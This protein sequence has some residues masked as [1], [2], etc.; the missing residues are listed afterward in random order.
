MRRELRQRGVARDAECS[1]LS[2]GERR[3]HDYANPAAQR[4]RHERGPLLRRIAARG[5]A[6]VRR[7]VLR[8]RRIPSGGAQPRPRS[9]VRLRHRRGGAPRLLRQLRNRARRRHRRR[10]ARGCSRPRPA[11]RGLPLSALLDHRPAAR[12][13]RPAR[14]ALLRGAAPHPR[15]AAPRRRLGERQ[16]TRDGAGRQSPRCDPRRASRSGLRGGASRA[17]RAGLRPSPEARAHHHRRLP[18]SVRALP[19]A[20]RKSADDAARRPPREA[21]RPEALRL[22]LHTPLQKSPADAAVPQRYGT[23]TKAATYPVIP[24]R[25]RCGRARRTTIC[26]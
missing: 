13:R 22:R 10:R 12:A 5:F 17:E 19:L 15:Q 21:P 16:A 7:P 3:E 24:G 6:E 26:S 4:G 9:R 20:R 25:A 11:V 1:I 14:D 8:H 23:R 2:A 18:P